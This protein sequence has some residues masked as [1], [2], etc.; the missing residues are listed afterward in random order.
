MATYTFSDNTDYQIP[1]KNLSKIALLTII[2]RMHNTNQWG[3]LYSYN[4]TD[5]E[6]N[7]YQITTSKT[8]KP[9]GFELKDW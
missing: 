3:N 4:I 9:N 1:A 6:G 7:H 8:G 5:E 2:K